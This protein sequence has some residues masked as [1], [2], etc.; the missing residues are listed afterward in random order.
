MFTTDVEADLPM[1][2]AADFD[3]AFPCLV[4]T[5]TDLV[6]S[7]AVRV[8][9][10]PTEAEEV[11]QDTFVRAYRALEGYDSERRTQMR[12]KPWLAQIA[13]NLARNRRRFVMRW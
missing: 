10:D 12:F 3:A 4:R 7:V 5:Y 6:Y 11:A 9:R 13:L 2:L 1:L 8:V